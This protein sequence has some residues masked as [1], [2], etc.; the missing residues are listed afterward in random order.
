M[1]FLLDSF[2]LGPEISRVAASVRENPTT[3]VPLFQNRRALVVG[4]TKGIGSGI[5]LELAKRGCGRVD[6]VG[7]DRIA[8]TAIQTA[9]KQINASCL[10]EH[11]AADLSTV[12]GCR[13]FVDTL[14]GKNN[15]DTRSTSA[16]K[17]VPPAGAGGASSTAA[18]RGQPAESRT[19]AKAGVSDTYDL[20]VFTVGVW[21]DFA[22]PLTPDGFNRVVF[23]D[24]LSRY[25]LLRYLTQANLL[26]SAT[27]KKLP[28]AVISV[29]AS[30]QKHSAGG[31]DAATRRS[32]L[33]QH[34]LT[35]HKT[36]EARAAYKENMVFPKTLATAGV[37]HDQMLA[38][39]FQTANSGSSGPLS[40]DVIGTFPGL[41]ETGVMFSTFGDNFFSRS[42]NFLGR[43]VPGTGMQSVEECGQ[44][45]VDVLAEVLQRR[46][47][48]E[49]CKLSF[50]SA[51]HRSERAVP[52]MF[53]EELSQWFAAELDQVAKLA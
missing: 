17:S 38:A 18:A 41:V 1:N 34:V 20:V 23:V 10:C 28:V 5:A 47:S 53:T 24:V 39:F 35:Q 13:A 50:W 31:Q 44:A 11:W 37:S 52:E 3:T 49:N 45:H 12:A 40:V 26:R 25:L 19:G 48:G 32:F 2:A 21:P 36:E 43:N 6:I 22:N 15:P 51:V 46:Q 42:L 16:N 33:E 9:M 27:D 29:L 30:G 7:R 8:G 14:Q 4:G